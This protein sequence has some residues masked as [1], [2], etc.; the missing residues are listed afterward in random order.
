VQHLAPKPSD[1]RHQ[2]V[3]RQCC[4]ARVQGGGRVPAKTAAKAAEILYMAAT[5]AIR[6]N[7]RSKELFDRL[8]AK[9]KPPKV[10]KV[11]VMHQL[12]CWAFAVVKSGKE[13]DPELDKSSPKTTDKI[14]F[15]FFLDV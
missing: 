1:E 11:A 9:G 8:T 7:P 10:A 13:Y 4:R 3:L 2:D 5:A 14:L 12:V 15:A 6:Y